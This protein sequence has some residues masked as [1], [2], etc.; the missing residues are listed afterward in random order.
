LARAGELM[1][2]SREMMAHRSYFRGTRAALA[3]ERLR[4]ATADGRASR[5]Q[6][7]ECL[8]TVRSERS[9]SRRFPPELPEALRLMGTCHWLIGHRRRTISW[10][11][12]SAAFA[13]RRGAVVELAN[14]LHDAGVLLGDS[15][16]GPDW[17]ARARALCAELGMG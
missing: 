17:A 16:P 14:T 6:S 9:A 1:R 7:R 12:R 5:A 10:W 11:K 3:V 15:A 13:E 8:A 4:R 2:G